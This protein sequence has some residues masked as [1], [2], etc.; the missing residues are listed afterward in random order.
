[1]DPLTGL[2]IGGFAHSSF[3]NLMNYFQQLDVFDWNKKQIK[4]QRDREDTAVQRRVEDLK[5]AGLHPTLAAGGAGSQSAPA[6]NLNAPQQEISENILASMHM[7]AGIEHTLAQNAL[8]EL[9][10]QHQ[11]TMNAIANNE[12]KVSDHDTALKL[13]SPVRSDAGS[14]LGVDVNT[15]HQY[16]EKA[17]EEAVSFFSKIPRWARG[18]VKGYAK[19][20]APWLPQSLLNKIPWL[21]D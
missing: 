3:N 18:Y 11:S 7:K 21:K 13:K 19:I 8:L 20:F 5:K 17:L 12:K 2:A 6:H 14:I 1:M 16:T 9:Q 15:A 10:A 4:I